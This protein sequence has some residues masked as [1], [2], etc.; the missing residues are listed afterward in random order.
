VYKRQQFWTPTTTVTPRGGYGVVGVLADPLLTNSLIAS[1]GVGPDQGTAVGTL[2]ATAGG[3]WLQWQAIAWRDERIY[4]DQV[5]AADGELHAYGENVNAA[6]FRVGQGLAGITR[7]IFAYAAAGLAEVRTIDRL[8]DGYDQP[9]TYVTAPYNGGQRYGE[10][11]V[12][13]TSSTVFP[14]SYTREDGPLV[15][16]AARKTWLDDEAAS[17]ERVQA[18]GSWVFSVWPRAGHQLVLGGI[19]GWSRSRQL[20]MQQ[21]F[22]IGGTSGLDLPRGYPVLVALGRHLLGYTAA[23]RLPVWRP[24]AGVSTTPFVFRQVVLEGFLDGAKAS[25]DSIGG[26]G[27]WYR[28][29]G[30]ELHLDLLIANLGLDPGIGYAH[31]LDGDQDGS[32]YL[33]LEYRW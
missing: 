22:Q 32:G 29:A 14:T 7:R 30:A 19:I 24:F 17:V 31:Q 9:T 15:V 6:E 13:Y 26:D 3:G 16:L 10:I 1:L 27:R 28:A 33:T 5:F 18:Q 11:A 25:A 2:A 21:A 4:E 12:G 20:W 23:Y 8:V